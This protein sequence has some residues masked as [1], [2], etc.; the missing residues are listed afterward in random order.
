MLYKGGVGVNALADLDLLRQVSA[1]K[2]VYFSRAWSRFDLAV[3]GTLRLV[4][5]AP[6]LQELARDYDQMREEMIFGDA[7]DLPALLEVL[8]EIE[9]RVNQG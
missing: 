5:P 9:Q 1:H 8:S 4:P 2:A 6:R 7:P 3:P